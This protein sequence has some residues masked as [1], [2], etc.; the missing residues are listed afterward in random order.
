MRFQGADTL[1]VLNNHPLTKEEIMGNNRKKKVAFI[2]VTMCKK[3]KEEK[4]TI[5]AYDAGQVANLLRCCGTLPLKIERR[6]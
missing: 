4:G 2:Y 6:I 3:G 1:N 5:K